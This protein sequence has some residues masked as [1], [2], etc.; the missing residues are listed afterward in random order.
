[1]DRLETPSRSFDE[2][3]VLEHNEKK[4]T[5]K[6][7]ASNAGILVGVLIVFMVVVVMT[8][9]IR[10]ITKEEMA[11]MWLHF[12]LLLFCTYSMHVSCSH[13]GMS[14]GY[15]NDIYVTAETEYDTKKRLILS[16]GLQSRL[17]R[18][19]RHY[20]DE[21]LKQTRIN[22]LAVVGFS[23]EEYIEKWCQADDK[24]IRH[25]TLSKTQKRALIKANRVEPI[26]LTPEMI[27][28]KARGHSKRSPLG[29]NP[30]T[31]KAVHFSS[32]LVTTVLLT[33]FL[34]AMVMQLVAEPTWAMVATC[35]IRVC[36][37]IMNGFSGYK[38]GFENIVFDTAGYMNDQ[39][40]LMDQA[41]LYLEEAEYA[42]KTRNV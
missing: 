35:I 2:S 30:N 39:G 19:C 34:S 15:Q 18:F 1:M 14:K 11:G 8:T 24:Q 26:K 16:R 25:S 13:T 42:D 12:L 38:F 28:R 20:I 5:I 6:K 29:T 10:L 23:W 27:M 32:Y 4:K 37:V 3:V 33:F 21:E 7:I 31:K 41:I 36:A 9:D 22:I 40:D 17:G